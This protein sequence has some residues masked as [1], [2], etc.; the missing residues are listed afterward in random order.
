MKIHKTKI[1]SYEFEGYVWTDELTIAQAKVLKVHEH[2]MR[3]NDMIYVVADIEV[4]W[5]DDIPMPMLT[6][7]TLWNGDEFLELDAS[8]HEYLQT[9]VEEAGLEGEWAEDRAGHLTDYAYNSMRDE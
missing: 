7:L 6:N 2:Q 1:S 8:D 9:Q 4:E 3:S 5:D